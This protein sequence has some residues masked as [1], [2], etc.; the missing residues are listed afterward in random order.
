[1]L[2]RYLKILHS[3]IKRYWLSWDVIQHL[4]LDQKSLVA[5]SSVQARFLMVSDD[6]EVSLDDKK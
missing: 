6:C 3:S 2:N 4:M 5:L 1:M